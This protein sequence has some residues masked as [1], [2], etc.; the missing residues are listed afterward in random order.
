MTLHWQATTPSAEARARADEIIAAF[1]KWKK[2]REPRDF[3]KT[4]REANK[5]FK[6]FARIQDEVDATPAQTIEGLMAKVRCAQ[7]WTAKGAKKMKS[8]DAGAET[9]AL[10]ILDDLDQLA[11]AS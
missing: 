11:V 4:E 7:A 10:S 6:A 8:L 9:M 1:D 3:K 5:A 2:E